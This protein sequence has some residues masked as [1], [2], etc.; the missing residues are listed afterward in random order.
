MVEETKA[1]PLRSRR[2]SSVHIGAGDGPSWMPKT[3][4]VDGSGELMN[5]YIVPTTQS[6]MSEEYR[7]NE[8]DNT[9]NIEDDFTPG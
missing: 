4:S 2:S 1:S 6:M 5:K 3:D 9:E 7:N 8:D